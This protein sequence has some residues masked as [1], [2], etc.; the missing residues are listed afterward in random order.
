MKCEKCGG[1]LSLEDVVCPHCDT[2][3]EH[4]VQHIRDMNKY[5]KDYEGTK[6]EVYTVTKSYAGISVRIVI[7]AILVVLI[8]ACSLL[9]EEFYSMK[10]KSEQAKSKKNVTE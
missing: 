4:A 9:S 1:N 3:N 8:V 10:R 7:I 5:K 2:L 6:Q